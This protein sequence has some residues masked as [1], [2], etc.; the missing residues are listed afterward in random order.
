MKKML[1][2]PSASLGSTSEAHSL[3]PPR[4]PEMPVVVLPGPAP[5][6][7]S[8]QVLSCR[9]ATLHAARC[10]AA[11]SSASTAAPCED[12]RHETLAR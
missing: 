4:R 9:A 12:H 7:L 10:T 3:R 2:S 11:S 8:C 5:A 6:H 1:S